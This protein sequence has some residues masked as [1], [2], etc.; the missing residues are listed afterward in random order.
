MAKIAIITGPPGSGK[1]TVSKKLAETSTKGAVISVDEIRHM[2]IGGYRKAWLKDKESEEQKILA[3]KNTCLLAKN[4]LEQGIDVF[5]D[6]VVT[7][8]SSLSLYKKLLNTNFSIFL[9]LPSKEVLIKRDASRPEEAI[10]GKRAIELHEVFS[11]AKDK[12]NWQ[13]IDTTSLSLEDT[14]RE[15]MKRR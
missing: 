9:L 14:V 12:L 6:D 3:I 10:M 13:V 8:E 4:F 11:S 5:I 1:T 7:S 15:I 2:I